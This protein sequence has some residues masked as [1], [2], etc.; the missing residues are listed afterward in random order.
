MT[1]RGP[2]ARALAAIAMLAIALMF[3]PSLAAAQVG[4]RNFYDPMIAVD[5]NPS[6]ELQLDPGWFKES[7]KSAATFSFALEKQLSDTISLQVGD[8]INDL[9][10]RRLHS[11]TGV[12]N[13]EVMLM[14]AFYTSVEHEFRLGLAFDAFLPTGDVDSGAESHPRGGPIL[15]FARGLGDLPDHDCFRFAR[16]FAIQG[17]LDYLPAWSGQE[18]QLVEANIA[19][20]YEAYYL[21]DAGIALPAERFTKNLVPFTEFNYQ[22]VA[23]GKFT[24]APPDWRITPGLAYLT[25]YYQFAA[26]TQLALNNAASPQDNSAVLFQLSIFY[27]QIWPATGANLF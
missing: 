27:D 12:D 8:A 22:Q 26:A 10:K 16:P 3:R 13:V 9:S 4:Q 21:S 14:W 1:R 15:S 7:G 11:S 2:D 17:D 18:S 5:P 6:N 24:S 20:S 25:Q 23:F 19:L